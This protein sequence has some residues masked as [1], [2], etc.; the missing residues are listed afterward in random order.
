MWGFRVARR[1][2]SGVVRRI[3]I[4]CSYKSSTIQTVCISVSSVGF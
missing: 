4:S 1:D 3:T 2:E